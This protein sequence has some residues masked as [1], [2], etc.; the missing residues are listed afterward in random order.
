MHYFRKH[1]ANRTLDASCGQRGE[2]LDHFLP[3]VEPI[4]GT[5]PDRR[6]A[7]AIDDK[8]L[9]NT[10]IS[11]NTVNLQRR[12]G[13]VASHVSL[14]LI[15]HMTSG[16]AELQRRSPCL[17]RQEDVKAIFGH[18]HRMSLGRVGGPR[19][20]LTAIRESN[21]RGHPCSRERSGVPLRPSLRVH[22]A[23][24][25]YD[26]LS[27]LKCECLRIGK[28]GTRRPSGPTVEVE[29]DSLAG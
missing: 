17:G 16:S 2:R 18:S 10:H 26:P 12:P 15:N 19:V 24:V 1:P 20:V 5:L 22:Q 23:L 6:I 9:A 21:D 29:C 11:L 4:R 27:F 13:S 7:A 14:R 3:L 25:D 8:G 28:G